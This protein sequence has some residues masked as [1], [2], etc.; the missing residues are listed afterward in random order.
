MTPIGLAPYLTSFF[1][2]TSTSA[3]GPTDAQNGHSGRTVESR[4]RVCWFTLRRVSALTRGLILKRWK[5]P[6]KVGS[7]RP[8]AHV[9]TLSNRTIA[10]DNDS[11]GELRNIMLVR[12]HHDGESAIV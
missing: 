5:V 9:F 6:E 11:L 3:S 8:I 10:E 12:D 1:A 7:H 4:N 2:T